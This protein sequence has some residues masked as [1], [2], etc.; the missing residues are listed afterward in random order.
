MGGKRRRNI[1]HF[2]TTNSAT[3][4]CADSGLCIASIM[5]YWW[6]RNHRMINRFMPD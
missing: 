1:R 5:P 3:N 6:P 4:R 2:L